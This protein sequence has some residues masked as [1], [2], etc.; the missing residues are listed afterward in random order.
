[1]AKIPNHL[2]NMDNFEGKKG[3]LYPHDYDNHVVKQRYLPEE[4]TGK[5]YYE[6]AKTGKYE[7]SL[8]ERMDVINR[9]LGK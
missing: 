2:I 3:Y 8:K 9:I 4:M 1:M 7:R 6:P 5:R